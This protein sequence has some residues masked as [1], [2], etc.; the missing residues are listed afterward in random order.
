M[1][2][3][4][5]KGPPYKTDHFQKRGSHPTWGSLF[6]KGAP[7]IKLI[8]F[9]KGGSHPTW[10]IFSKRG[11]PYKADH[12]SKKGPHPTWG[13][14]SQKRGSHPTW[15]SLFSKRGG[16]FAAHVNAPPRRQ[17]EWDDPPGIWKTPAPTVTFRRLEGSSSIRF[18]PCFANGDRTPSLRQ[19]PVSKTKPR[20]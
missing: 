19:D 6:Q 9:R 2:H 20:L 3:F 5:K 4:F 14:L 1:G 12:F 11:S 7:L 8:I 17:G 10:V 18:A 16:P 13:S 15:G